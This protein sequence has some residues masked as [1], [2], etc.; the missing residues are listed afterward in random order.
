MIQEASANTICLHGLR[1]TE[2]ENKLTLDI[3]THIVCGNKFFP[4]ENL[5][6]LESLLYVAED[7]KSKHV[8][9]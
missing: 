7:S 8:D 6:S 4:C 1:E 9:T 5:E 3:N 2:E